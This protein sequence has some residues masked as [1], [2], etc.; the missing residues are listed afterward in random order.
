VTPAQ[1]FGSSGPGRSSTVRLPL[2]LSSQRPSRS[3]NA[4]PPSAS[5]TGYYWFCIV[6]DRVAMSRGRVPS[7]ACNAI[8]ARHLGSQCALLPSTEPS[9]VQPSDARVRLPRDETRTPDRGMNP[10]TACHAL[11]DRER[12]RIGLPHLGCTTPTIDDEGQRD[13]AGGIASRAKDVH[14]RHHAGGREC[15]RCTP[16]TSV[17]S[18]SLPRGTH[19]VADRCSVAV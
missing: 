18:S 19:A 6:P 17:H 16:K 14:G 3:R 9:N 13:H 8:H 10:R 15:V 1:H 4:Q 12:R 7:P 11:R 5:V 2:P